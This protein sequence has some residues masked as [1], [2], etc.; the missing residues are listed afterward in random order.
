VNT[1]TII[2]GMAVYVL[3]FLATWAWIHYRKH[4]HRRW[5]DYDRLTDR[6]G[7]DFY[8]DGAP[9]GP[10]GRVWS[11]KKRAEYR[12]ARELRKLRVIQ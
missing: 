12:R 7:I 3:F 10:R 9:G 8:E 11:D 5:K 6:D 4:L 1:K 2:I